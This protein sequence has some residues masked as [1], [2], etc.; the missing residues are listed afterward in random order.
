[1]NIQ[2]VRE[3]IK[4]NQ[5]NIDY[6]TKNWLSLEPLC[7]DVVFSGEFFWYLKTLEETNHDNY[8]EQIGTSPC[9]YLPEKQNVII[10]R[11]STSV[12][13]YSKI[14]GLNKASIFLKEGGGYCD[15]YLCRDSKITIPEDTLLNEVF[16]HSNC[17][18][19]D[20]GNGTKIT[21]GENCILILNLSW[22]DMSAHLRF[23]NGLQTGSD[24]F[25]RPDYVS[26]WPTKISC[27]KNSAVIVRY[28]DSQKEKFFTYKVGNDLEENTWYTFDTRECE[29]VK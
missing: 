22:R 13:L 23:L 9:R 11:N 3:L 17:Q 8:R 26:H 16:A 20:S 1:M 4:Q 14:V 28:R 10:T 6:V 12:R 19:E 18:I 27:G 24:I 21:T 15:A 5:F 25:I 29:F 7:N 2:I